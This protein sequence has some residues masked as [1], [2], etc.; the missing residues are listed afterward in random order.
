M[1]T[2]LM[3]S[4]RVLLV[5][6]GLFTLAAC[7]DS[8]DDDSGMN[9]GDDVMAED[10]AG[11]AAGLNTR[12]GIRSVEESIAEVQAFVAGN[13]ALLSL[14]P[15]DHA[16]NATSVEATL[17]AT[18]VIF[19]GNPALGTPLMVRNRLAGLDLPQ[20]MLA[21]EDE[22]GVVNIAYNDVEWLT[23]RH[24]LEGVESLPMIG[25]ALETIAT[26]AAGTEADA[27]DAPTGDDADD[28][29][30]EPGDAGAGGNADEDAS[31]GDDAEGAGVMAGEGI[32][33]L[34]STRDFE[35]TYNALRQAIESAEPLRLVAEVD[36]SLNASNAG[37]SLPPTRLIV[38]GNPN[39]GTPLMQSSQSVAIDLPQKML[40]FEADEVVTVA[41]NDPAFTA[42]R[43]GITD[44][45]ENIGR[46]AGALA[47]LAA[48][49]AGVVVDEE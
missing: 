31:P 4:T 48:G 36:H 42:A 41:W 12:A 27:D 46:I 8:N 44:Q 25:G 20:K 29:G 33:T 23:A 2:K 28:M 10:G 34:V 38:F 47:G 15:V 1:E 11:A 9:G 24:E 37:L 19:F 26:R 17:R 32:E 14:D 16:A 7:S 22:A 35:T 40:V 49:A 6:L 21:Y 45:D 30:D 3:N 43:H 5:S 13:D 39:L 18:S